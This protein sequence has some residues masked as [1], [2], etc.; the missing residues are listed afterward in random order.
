MKSGEVLWVLTG[1]YRS[2]TG[3]R[4]A[5]VWRFLSAH[6]CSRSLMGFLSPRRIPI[7]IGTWLGW[8]SAIVILAPAESTRLESVQGG[9]NPCPD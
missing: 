2:P 5:S 6:G 7:P 4:L 3:N 9:L 1:L 8:L